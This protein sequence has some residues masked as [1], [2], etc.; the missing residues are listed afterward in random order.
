[1]VLMTE[2]AVV[3]EFVGHSADCIGSPRV[4]PAVGKDLRS[5]RCFLPQLY[6]CMVGNREELD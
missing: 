5:I 6:N 1:M 2:F 3:K 4:T